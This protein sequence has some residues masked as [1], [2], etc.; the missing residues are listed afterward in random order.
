M[1]V[2]LI[3]NLLNEFLAGR[4]K[5]KLYVFDLDDTLIVGNRLAH[6]THA[7]LTELKTRKYK[8]CVASNN[9]SARHILQNLHVE[10]YFDHI[11]GHY[12]EHHKGK[13]LR[14]IEVHYPNIYPHEIVLFDDLQ[15]NVIEAR[16]LGI[17][18]CS[19]G[20][21]HRCKIVRFKFRLKSFS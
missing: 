2:A 13:H 17:R 14:Q 11:I 20:S 8:M 10:H 19:S 15:E 21:S 18:R 3:V 7:V 9:E 6:D 16:K 12:D 5:Y 4:P 1:P